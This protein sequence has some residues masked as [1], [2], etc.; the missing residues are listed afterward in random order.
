M[1]RKCKCMAALALIV[2][3]ALSACG[4]QGSQESPEVEDVSLIS[5]ADAYAYW[6]DSRWVNK[7]GAGLYQSE[8]HSLYLSEVVEGLDLEPDGEY[9]SRSTD[10]VT[11][12]NSVYWLDGFYRETQEGW[13]HRY[14]V[15]RYDGASGEVQHSPVELPPPEEYGADALV[16]ASFDVRGERELVL[17]LQGQQEGAHRAPCY[18]AMHITPEGEMLS[19]TDIY[20]AMQELGIKTGTLFEAAWV[21]RDGYYY[22]IPSKGVRGAG[23]DVKVLNPD[24]EIVGTMNP[25]EEYEMADWVMK[26]P[27][28]SAVFC[29]AYRENAHNLLMAVYDKEK[30]ASRTLQEGGLSGCW[31]WTPA[32]DGYLYYVD[33]LGNL[34]RCDIRTGAV[35]ELMY[36]P[37]LGMEGVGRSSSHL[38]KIILGEDGEPEILGRRD[39]ETVVCRLSAEKPETESLRLLSKNGFSS[40][41]QHCA[42]SYSKEHAD[43]PAMLEYSEEEDVDAYWQRAMAELVSGKGA[44]LYYVRA[45][46]MRTLQ[47][48]GA[49][50]DLSELISEETLAAIWPGVLETHTVGGQLVGISVKSGVRTLMVSDEIWPGDHWTLRQALDVI[51]AHPEMRYP[52]IYDCGFDSEDILDWL[53]LESLAAGDSP[54]LNLEEGNCDFD[55]PLFVRALEVAGAYEKPVDYDDAQELY[56]EKDWVAM[57]FY[58]DIASFARHKDVLGEEYHVVGFPTEGE[59]GTYYPIGGCWVV[60]SRSEHMQE[61]AAFL[62]EMVSY[63]NQYSERDPAR[64]DMFPAERIVPYNVPG[65]SWMVIEWGGGYMNEMSP[66][67]QGDYRLG[68]YHEVMEKGVAMRPGTDA[69]ADIILEEAAGYFSGTRDAAS[70]ASII[71]NRVQLYLK[72]RQ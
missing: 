50:A 24:G 58:C 27:D 44:D 11:L 54:F 53:V 52:L 36:Y 65:V 60:S 33:F 37:L 39:G 64:R 3:L 68:E 12:G 10:Y 13:E 19:V 57:M 35:E 28:G 59:S 29:W 9:D 61:A 49:L 16:V 32:R 63:E 8:R 48:K 15:S 71:Q 38:V 72:E 21:D 31:L 6:S 47:E 18:L 45:S 5:D 43:C 41:E 56:L 46:E 62:E 34:K 55:N 22:L 1:K 66:G 69:I 20:P 14:Y 4:R 23:N 2:L 26:L 17:F 70:A 40:Y 30:N 25:G 51:E 42:V 7:E 67:P